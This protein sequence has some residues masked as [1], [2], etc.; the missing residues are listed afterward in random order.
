MIDFIRSG[1]DSPYCDDSS[2]TIF[3]GFDSCKKKR[4]YQFFSLILKDCCLGSID[5]IYVIKYTQQEFIIISPLKQTS[6]V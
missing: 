3:V 6:L 4:I 1:I 2:D 5:E